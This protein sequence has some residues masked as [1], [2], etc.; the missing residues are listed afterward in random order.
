MLVL[1]Y[2]WNIFEGGYFEMLVWHP[3]E[4]H[5]GGIMLVLFGH[6]F[7]TLLDFAALNCCQ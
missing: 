4:L 1:L 2:L 5:S 7:M 6:T 3:V